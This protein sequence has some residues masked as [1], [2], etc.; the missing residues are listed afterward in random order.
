MWLRDGVI[1]NITVGRGFRDF[2]Y[3]GQ[4]S[5]VKSGDISKLI[6]IRTVLVPAYPIMPFLNHTQEF[7]LESFGKY[8]NCFI[9]DQ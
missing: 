6:I 1:Q 8:S 9:L 4:W 7:V 2:L 3:V 5:E